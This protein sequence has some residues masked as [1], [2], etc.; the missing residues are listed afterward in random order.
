MG[1][2]GEQ[3]GD[4]GRRTRGALSRGSLLCVLRYNQSWKCDD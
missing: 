1:M 4:R 2:M 3:A